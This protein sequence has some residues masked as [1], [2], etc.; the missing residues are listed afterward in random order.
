M[1]S[2]LIAVTGGIGSGQSTVCQMFEEMG[3][4]VIHA[5]QVGK[6]IVDTNAKVKDELRIEFGDAIFDENNILKRKEFAKIVFSDK[7]RIQRLNR[8]VHPR[9]I[10]E[11]IEEIELAQE[12]GEY[13]FII[14]DGALIYEMAI[15]RFF[16][17]II[18]VYS[19]KEVRIKRVQERDKLSRR[20][21]ID[22]MDNQID[23]NEKSSWADYVIENNHSLVELKAEVY[24]VYNELK[25]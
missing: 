8:I 13:Q 24:K 15:E 16:D 4:K 14:I 20:E 10:K 2:K 5:D 23:L 6:Q 12:S 17:H 1:Q 22:R 7:N 21:I 18:V 11:L 9:L 25:N 19:K 3:C